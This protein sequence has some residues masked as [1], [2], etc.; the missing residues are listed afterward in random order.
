MIRFYNKIYQLLLLSLSDIVPRFCNDDGSHNID[1]KASGNDSVALIGVSILKNI[2]VR[3][4]FHCYF[5]VSGPVGHGL[6]FTIRTASLNDRDVV[7]VKSNSDLEKTWAGDDEEAEKEVLS[8]AN[9]EF[10]SSIFFSY[11]PAA[12]NTTFNSGLDIAVTVFRG[13]YYFFLQ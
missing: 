11:V 7:K 13:L 2:Q 4:N 10:P 1:L 8:I 6:I 12:E 3:P 5:S 9:Q